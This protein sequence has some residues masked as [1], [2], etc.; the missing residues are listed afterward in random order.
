MLLKFE[1]VCRKDRKDIEALQ[2]FPSQSGCIESVVECLEEADW[3]RE[4]RPVG[5]YDEEV[6]VGFAMYGFFKSPTKRVWLDRLIIDKKYQGKGY[7][8]ASVLALLEKLRREYN[9]SDAI[10]LSVYEDNTEAID[11]YQ[12]IGF[13]FNGECDAKGEKIMV[14]VF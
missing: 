11:L 8:T 4:W 12:R 7:G 3:I 13:S 1:P 14:Y 6:L 10:Y 2:M 9:E 5:I